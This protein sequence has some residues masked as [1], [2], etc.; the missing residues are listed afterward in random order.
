[1]EPVVDENEDGMG[2]GE[3]G[4]GIGED[5]DGIGEN[6]GGT[7]TVDVKGGVDELSM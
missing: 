1:M 3:D 6:Q 7:V 5:E 4:I 2:E